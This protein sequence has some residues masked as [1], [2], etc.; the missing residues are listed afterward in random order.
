MTN[1]SIA[2]SLSSAL[3]RLDQAT[4][5]ARIVA[6]SISESAVDGIDHRAA[7]MGVAYLIQG[8]YHELAEIE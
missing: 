6:N 1:A 3:S 5:L 2:D 4:H 7:V 8:I